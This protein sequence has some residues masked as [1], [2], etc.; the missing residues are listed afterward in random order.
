MTKEEEDLIST[1]RKSFDLNN[2]LFVQAS[3]T[4]D[5]IYSML[6]DAKKE[7]QE[8]KEQN[9]KLESS[10]RAIERLRAAD[11]WSAIQEETKLKSQLS[12]LQEK[13]HTDEKIKELLS[14]SD[15]FIFPSY[16]SHEGKTMW[17]ISNV[18]TDYGGQTFVLCPVSDG[19]NK[20]LDLAIKTITDCKAKYYSK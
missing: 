9:E 16:Y 13:V 12:D 17:K 7:N 2:D 18:F 4:F 11:G 6:K 20:A 14:I 5:S 15:E 19:F 10:V 8:L 1:Y 3:K